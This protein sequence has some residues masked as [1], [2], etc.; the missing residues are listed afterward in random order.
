MTRSPTVFPGRR[1]HDTAA[2]IRSG[3]NHAFAT[4]A[5]VTSVAMAA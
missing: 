1:E 4:W 3:R 5:D 2:N